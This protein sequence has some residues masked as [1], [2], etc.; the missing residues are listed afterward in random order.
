MLKGRFAFLGNSEY[1]STKVIPNKTYYKA[2][3]ISATGKEL[4]VETQGKLD[5]QQ[6]AQCDLTINIQQGKFPR[7]DYVKHELVK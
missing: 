3:F 5:I 2:K 4:E 1:T 7:F 6:F